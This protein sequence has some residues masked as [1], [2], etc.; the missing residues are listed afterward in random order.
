V[1]VDLFGTL[2]SPPSPTEVRAQM[3]LSGY[4]LPSEVHPVIFNGFPYALVL[5]EMGLAP[6]AFI[7]ENVSLRLQ[8]PEDLVEVVR[9]R[10]P[11]IKQ[12]SREILETARRLAEVYLEGC[13]LFE[14]AHEFLG[15][16][17]SDIHLISDLSACL[18]GVLDRLEIRSCFTSINFSFETGKRKWDGSAFSPWK[19]S[20]MVTMVG[21]SWKSDVLGAIRVNIQAILLDRTNTSPFAALL[22]D[23]QLVLSIDTAGKINIREDLI[24]WAES[25]IP[26]EIQSLRE[27]P[28]HH[29]T[30]LANGRI[31]WSAFKTVKVANSLTEVIDLLRSKPK[32]G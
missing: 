3:Q 30:L 32:R 14:D 9:Q 16:F 18:A 4:S 28:S 19:G 20:K 29:L 12:P 17:Q 26:M 31:A 1:L 25:L 11:E 21:D 22:N 24:P 27:N 13:S 8:K 15:E 23:A 6:E 7:S 10:Y 5:G 2:I